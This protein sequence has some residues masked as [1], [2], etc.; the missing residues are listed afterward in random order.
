MGGSG[1]HSN[2]GALAKGRLK[3]TAE[4]RSER[5][6]VERAADL[7]QVGTASEPSHLLATYSSAG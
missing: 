4:S 5:A 2:C 7:Q 6:V 1:G 3:D